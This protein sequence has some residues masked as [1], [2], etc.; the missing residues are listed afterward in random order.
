[1]KDEGRKIIHIFQRNCSLIS[2]ME[3]VRQQSIG[4]FERDFLLKN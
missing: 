1:M 2:A 4:I 3:L